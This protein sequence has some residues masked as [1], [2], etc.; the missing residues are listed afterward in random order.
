M[1]RVLR[2][3]FLAAALGLCAAAP[4][5]A[6]FDFP[7][8]RLPVPGMEDL[9]DLF[10]G[11]ADFETL[12]ETLLPVL[13]ML[14]AMGLLV[15][16]QDVASPPRLDPE[17][18]QDAID[19]PAALE[20][21]LPMGGTPAGLEQFDNLEQTD[22][23]FELMGRMP[24]LDECMLSML[25]IAEAGILALRG[26][27]SGASAIYDSVLPPLGDDAG[28][29]RLLLLSH[30]SHAALM[31]FQRRDDE[32]EALFEALLPQMGREFGSDAH[33]TLAVEEPLRT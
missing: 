14:G 15:P 27:L 12:V 2:S 19:D 13:E 32:A 10:S 18:C 9:G 7:I 1:K 8:D 31:V 30:A 26:D 5:K 6:Q 24:S 22:R 20:F 17:A 23:L 33:E 16:E 4:G 21:A 11:S 3:A 25:R 28:A 29:S